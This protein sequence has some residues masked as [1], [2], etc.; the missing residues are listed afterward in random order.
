M[1]LF[2]K[3][4]GEAAKLIENK[5]EEVIRSAAASKTQSDRIVPEWENTSQQVSPSGNSWGDEMPSEENQFNFKGNYR[6]YFEHIFAEDFSMYTIEKEIPSKWPMR[7]VYRLSR[8]GMTSV[9]I[10]LLPETSSTQKLRREC[11]DS[12]TPYLRFYYDHDGWWNTRS[13][14]SGR[15]NKAING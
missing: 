13:Y 11:A 15:I 14:V 3:L 2:N 12:G 4:F 7:T 1:G 10:E 9:V 5:G 8:G 6:E